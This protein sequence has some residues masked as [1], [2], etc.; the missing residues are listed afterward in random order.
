M[1]H[2][3][4]P[5]FSHD[6]QSTWWRELGRSAHDLEVLAASAEPDALP[7]NGKGECECRHNGGTTRPHCCSLYQGLLNATTTREHILSD[8]EFS[9]TLAVLDLFVLRNE[10]C[11]LV[12]GFCVC[13]R[14]RSST[15]LLEKWPLSGS[16]AAYGTLETAR[17][18]GVALLANVEC[19]LT[20]ETAVSSRVA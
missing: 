12:S 18:P 17:S 15:R 7:A 4:S 20:L 2:A 1:N 14:F 8:K 19:F 3:L 16:A 10:Q 13:S 6:D 5:I 11:N 9:S